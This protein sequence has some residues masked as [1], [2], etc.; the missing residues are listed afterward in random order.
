MSDKRVGIGNNYGIVN[1]GNGTQ[2]G[3][4]RMSVIARVIKSLAES[5]NDDCEVSR[6]ETDYEIEEKLEYN[7]LQEY[8][9]LIDDYYEK[10]ALITERSFRVAESERPGS[11]EKIFRQVNAFYR[12]ALYRRDG[13]NL[14]NRMQVI[15]NHADE[16]VEE[17]IAKVKDMVASSPELSVYMEEDVELGAGCIVGYSIIECQV[18][19]KPDNFL[20]VDETLGGA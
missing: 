3:T 2:S 6:V 4:S 7:N 15:R 18:L 12:R 5:S 13:R 1:I 20:H 10:Y 8:A 14:E 17:V 9:Y 19:E 11:T 16:I